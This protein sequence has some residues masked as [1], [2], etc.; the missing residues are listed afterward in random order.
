[1]NNTNMYQLLIT[2]TNKEHS[3]LKTFGYGLSY[4]IPIVNP[5]W[6]G[7]D[8]IIA[9]Q[10]SG[11]LDIMIHNVDPPV[12]LTPELFAKFTELGYVDEE[13]VAETPHSEEE[14]EGTHEGNLEDNS[15]TEESHETHEE[16]NHITGGISE[17]EVVPPTPT[18]PAT[19]TETAPAAPEPEPEVEAPASVDFR[20]KFVSTGAYRAGKK[21][22]ENTESIGYETGDQDVA[23]LVQVTGLKDT[24]GNITEDK[25]KVLAGNPYSADGL[26]FP[27]ELMMQ[28]DKPFFSK[29]SKGIITYI[30]AYSVTDLNGINNMGVALQVNGEQVGYASIYKHAEA[31]DHL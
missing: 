31:S 27:V 15:H 20:V 29:N 13:V 8:K 9:A 19:E 21:L 23:I 2:A 12:L 16:E 24:N 11:K 6:V 30:A 26:R 17:S 7:M 4:P 14:G 22:F 1:M 28:N 3:N 18:V 25:I 10:A 5:V